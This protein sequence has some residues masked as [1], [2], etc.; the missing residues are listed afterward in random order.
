L[1]MW[2]L[3]G[4]ASIPDGIDALQSYYGPNAY[5]GNFGCYQSDAFDEAYRKAMRLPDGPERT[6]LYQR[7]L[8]IMEADT[9]ELTELWQIRNWLIHPWVKGFKKHPILSGDWM[10]LDIDKH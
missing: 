4:T 2:G 6:A 5:Q 10:Y 8:R 7:M 1:S 9:V 3:G